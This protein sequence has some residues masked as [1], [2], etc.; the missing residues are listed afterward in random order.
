[1][2]RVLLVVVLVLALAGAILWFANTSSSRRGSRASESGAAMKAEPVSTAAPLLPARPDSAV[3]PADE[4]AA[5]AAPTAAHAARREAAGRDIELANAQWIDG[6][7]LFP[8]GTP[9]DEQVFV[10]ANGAGSGGENEHRVEVARD[11]SFRVAFGEKTRSGR[12]EL[13]ARY[14]YLDEIVRWKSKESTGQVVLEPK[15]GARIAGR[16]RLPAGTDARKVGGKLELEISRRSGSSY[17]SEKRGEQELSQDLAFAFD[18]LVPGVDGERSYEVSYDGEALIGR[19]G[20]LVPQAGKTLALELEL[21]PGVVLAGVVRDESGVPLSGVDVEAMVQPGSG[22]WTSANHRGMLSAADGSFRLGALAEGEVQLQAQLDGFVPLERELGRLGEGKSIGDLALVLE[23]G[24]SI[25]GTV[26]WPDGS[27][28]E[29]A[30]VLVPQLTGLNR[31]YEQDEVDGKSDASGAFSIG[32]LSE[33]AYRVTA[34]ATKTD[35]V[36]VKSEITGRERPKKQRTQWSAEAELVEVGTSGLVLT[37]STGLAVEGRVVDDLGRPLADFS[38]VANRIENGRQRFSPAGDLSRSYRDADGSFRMEG[39]APGRW[40]LRGQSKDH[41]ASDPMRVTLPGAEPV[42]LVVPREA[43]V[44]GRVLDPSGAPLAAA[45]VQVD[46][47]RKRNGFTFVDDGKAADENGFFE[48]DGL[49]PGKIVLQASGSSFAPSAPQTL[50]LAAGETLAGLVLRLRPG[51]TILGELVGSDGRPRTG[52]VWLNGAGFSAYPEADADGRFQVNGVPPG[53]MRLG[54]QTEEGLQIDQRVTLGEGETVRVRLAPPGRLVRL[55]GSVRA[56]GEPLARAGVSAMRS[57]DGK[58]PARASSYSQTLEDGTYEL[59][60]PGSGRYRISVH[61]RDER[62]LSWSDMLD[63]PDVEELELDV[64]IQVGRISGRV[65]DAQGRA[66]ADVLVMSEPEK[67]EGAAHGSAQALTDA[68]GRYEL[69]VPAGQHAVTAG[70]AR[71]TWSR[72][73]P[74]PFAEAR[75]GG[76]VVSANGHV[77]GIDLVLAQGAFLEGVVRNPDGSAAALAFLWSEDGTRIERIGM[78]DGNGQFRLTL[79]QGKYSVRATSAGST[80]SLSMG[81]S[82]VGATSEPERVVLAVGET[83]RIELA[84]SAARRVHLSV[85]QGATPVGSEVSVLD[86]RGRRQPVQ[87]GENGE[88]WL[89]PLVS[90]RYTVRAQ[91]DGKEVEREFE[92]GAGGEQM[93]VELVFE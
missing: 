19:A 32:G 20:N 81:S 24:S 88:A 64:S 80:V 44:S 69:L 92:V 78:C 43:V 73:E 86:E 38:I 51:G 54:A 87:S 55:H 27:P 17:D 46:E 41:A 26:R 66:L 10:T 35:E 91:R 63:A 90:G 14:L 7:V 49:G 37:L 52:N 25:S 3:L 76:L 62:V 85:R 5:G 30:L 58:A 50:E 22:S 56:G 11:G 47:E 40:E 53:E 61:G 79:A 60:L 4:P 12:F 68:E 48:I 67:H 8:A 39:F 82:S 77:R 2:N 29:S 21:L 28:A 45:T 42:V 72:P 84:L 1:M 6:R 70:G 16:V 74:Q 18:A 71:R 36:L 15:L 57:D 83:R 33:K 89:G 34:R 23:R 93:E 75:V 59:Q 9:D 65:T 31:A 13:D